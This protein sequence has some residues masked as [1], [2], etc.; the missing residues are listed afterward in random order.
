MSHRRQDQTATGPGPSD[1]FWYARLGY[2]GVFGDSFTGG[3]A[4]GFGFRAA[5]D[6]FGIDMSFLNFKLPGSGSGSVYGSSPDSFATAVLKLETLYLV[7]PRANATPYLG[8]GISYGVTNI[9]GAF[10]GDGFQS[11]SHGSGLQGELTAGYEWPQ[12]QP[13]ACIRAGR[14][15]PA[16][17]QS[18]LRT[19]HIEGL[20][21]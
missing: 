1:T 14:C 21:P 15:H 19:I 17:L 11:N 13:A 3:P 9:D 20:I 5:F 12:G 2:G 10:V 4:L 16:V 8:G 18:G 6:S 7:N